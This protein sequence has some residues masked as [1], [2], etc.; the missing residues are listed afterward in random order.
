MSKIRTFIAINA[1]EKVSNNVMRVVD[2]LA[3]SKAGYRWVAPESLHLTLNFVGD[4][5]DI[6]VPE[7]CKL[8]RSAV[9][10]LPRFDLSLKG[11]SAFPNPEQPRVIWIGV[12][13]GSEAMKTMYRELE[14]ALYEWG[15]N[16][17]RKAF[18][19]HMTLGRV[20]RDGRWNDALLETMHR[21]R[22]HDGGF[23][24]VREV[25][26]YSSYLDRS[27]PTYTPMSRIKLR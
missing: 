13:E 27:G 15:V 4:V 18:V 9:E 3:D 24:T 5:N 10:H 12:D 8:V 20:A 2:R 11:V 26:V 23:C 16:K 19:P 7:L 25:I 6:E 21:L 14:N 17:D 22:N 1:S